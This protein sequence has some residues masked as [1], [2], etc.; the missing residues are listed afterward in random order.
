M[1]WAEIK[2]AVNSTICTEDFQPL[3]EIFKGS[4]RFVACD[5]VTYKSDTVTYSR[6]GSAFTLG[7]SYTAAADG[8]LTVKLLA[9]TNSGITCT[10]GAYVNGALFSSDERSVTSTAEYTFSN[11]VTFKKGDVLTFKFT[12]S[13]GTSA[14][15][16]NLYFLGFPVYAPELLEG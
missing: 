12:R 2:K 6:N 3:D 7:N 10:F 8:T 13:S 15:F 11:N 16:G 1:S 9:T 14:T 5:D 4:W